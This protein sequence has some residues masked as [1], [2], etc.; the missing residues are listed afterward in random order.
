MCM[1]SV[2][3]CVCSF[4]AAHLRCGKCVLLCVRLVLLSADWGGGGDD[5]AGARAR[6]RWGG[7][8]ELQRSW[9]S[10]LGGAVCAC[11]PL[12]DDDSRARPRPIICYLAAGAPL[13]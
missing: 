2:C 11:G 3:V 10:A 8:R 9:H 4:A 12:D 5:E 6:Q 13:R 1:F 7:G